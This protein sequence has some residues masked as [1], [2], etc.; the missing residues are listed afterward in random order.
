VSIEVKRNGHAR[1]SAAAASE[2]R[3]AA[4]PSCSIVIPTYNEAADI[5]ETLQHALGQTLAASEV[6]VVDG[7]SRD[8]TVEELWRWRQSGRVSVIEEGRRRGVAAA[9]NA[10][11]RSAT[12]DIVVILNADVLL[13]P[14]FLAR[15]AGVYAQGGV[16]MLSVD[17][18]VANLDAVTGRYIH[19]VH[20]ARYGA[21]TVGWSEGFSCRRE[22]ALRAL[23]PEEIPGAGGEDVEFVD[24]LLRAGCRWRV[25]Y[26]ICVR[27]RVPATLAGFWQQFYGRGCA[28]PHIERSL[29]RWPLPVV[30]V[31][32]AAVLAKTLAT[33]AVV[34]PHA[35]RALEL[36]RHSPRGRRDA[37]PFWLLHH[38]LL[39]AHR[40]GEWRSLRE[41][42]R[43]R[44]R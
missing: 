16:D 31:R 42:W 17:S 4:L 38:L 19:A 23:F 10:G 7:G 21:A 34:A 37:V 35:A 41:M 26:S 6:I 40:A 18:V 9:R 15:V 36:A 27:H 12:G 32:R 43:G 29:R 24:R 3:A 5:G 1:T 13:P 11:I 28:V 33:T 39:A 2:V 30:T 44:R 14:D 22:A 25:D 8:G 20:R